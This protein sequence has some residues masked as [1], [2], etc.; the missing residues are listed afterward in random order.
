MVEKC[1]AQHARG[2]FPVSSDA[3]R[4]MLT[5]CPTGGLVNKVGRVIEANGGVVVCPDD[6]MGERTN[7][8]L[9]DEG[10]DDILRAIAERYLSISCSVMTP[11]AGRMENTATLVEK[12]RVDGI[13][14][15]VLTTCHTFN[16]ESALM[17]RA[18]E[19]RDGSRRSRRRR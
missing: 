2:D 6:C 15:C 17:Q 4:I 16:V 8:M 7:R 12:Y 9:V 3:K 10:A 5:G 18:M 19:E 1:R 14:D 11:N 13:V